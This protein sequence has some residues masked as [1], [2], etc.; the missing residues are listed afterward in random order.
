VLDDDDD[1]DDD[2]DVKGFL[3]KSAV[4]KFLSWHVLGE[5]ENFDK[6]DIE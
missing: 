5:V 4:P 6:Q 3:I 2:D 1:D